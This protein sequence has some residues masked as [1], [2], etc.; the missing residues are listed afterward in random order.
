MYIFIYIIY[1]Y[2]IY[3]YKSESKTLMYRMPNTVG[4][5]WILIC[6]YPPPPFTKPSSDIS[7]WFSKQR[8]LQTRYN[9]GLM[10]RILIGKFKP[11]HIVYP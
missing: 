5:C 7:R 4:S 1:I 10:A 11:T 6:P 9:D 8:L 2:Y 3:I